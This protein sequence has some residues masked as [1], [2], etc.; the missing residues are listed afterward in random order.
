LD[1]TT[2]GPKGRIAD[3]N[4]GDESIQPTRLMKRRMAIPTWA[5]IL[6]VVFAV[7]AAIGF[8]LCLAIT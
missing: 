1:L 8:L 4:N 2:I 3:T 7:A 5:V 6:V